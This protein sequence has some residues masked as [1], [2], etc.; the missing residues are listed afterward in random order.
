MNLKEVRCCCTPEN[1]IGYVPEDANLPIRELDDG[2]FAFTAENHDHNAVRQME[3][4]I[5]SEGKGKKKK[6]RR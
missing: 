5:E 2:S 3:G 4:F 1:L 6:W